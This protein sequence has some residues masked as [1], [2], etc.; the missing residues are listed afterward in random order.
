MKHHHG[1]PTRRRND[2]FPTSLH[3]LSLIS[4][5]DV[6][7]RV[8]VMDVLIKGL[9]AEIAGVVHGVIKALATICGM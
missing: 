3:K 5:H 1:I 2:G 6:C 7:E 9:G 4:S 8:S